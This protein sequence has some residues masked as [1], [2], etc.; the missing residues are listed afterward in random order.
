[1]ITNIFSASMIDSGKVWCVRN[2][3]SFSVDKVPSLALLSL[4]R[5]SVVYLGVGGRSGS[6]AAYA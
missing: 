6:F 4:L 5:A 2:Q 3:L 1:M